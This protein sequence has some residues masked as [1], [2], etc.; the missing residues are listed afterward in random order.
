MIRPKSVESSP[1]VRKNTHKS[2]K[3]Y[4][5][6]HLH[7]ARCPVLGLDNLIR[8]HDLHAVRPDNGINAQ[9]VAVLRPPPVLCHID[10]VTFDALGDVDAVMDG[11]AV[12]PVA[13]LDAVAVLDDLLLDHR[14]AYTAAGEQQPFQFQ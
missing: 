7:Y 6:A 10:S 1:K 13:V 3:S 12:Y 8:H 2:K 14:F 11:N 9:L 4:P 5:C